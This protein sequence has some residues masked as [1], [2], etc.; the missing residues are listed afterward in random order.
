MSLEPRT[1]NLRL[2]SERVCTDTCV[3]NTILMNL[4]FSLPSPSRADKGGQATGRLWPTLC[5]LR[6]CFRPSWM[7]I[8]SCVLDTMVTETEK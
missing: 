8:P 1:Y 5:C 3:H 6:P 7:L 4:K 2:S